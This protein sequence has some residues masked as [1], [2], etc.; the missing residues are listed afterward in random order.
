[1]SISN[2]YLIERQIVTIAG[3]CILSYIIPESRVYIIS[4]QKSVQEKI[5]VIMPLKE[6]RL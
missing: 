1:M 6:E 5:I 4:Q 2:A 3:P